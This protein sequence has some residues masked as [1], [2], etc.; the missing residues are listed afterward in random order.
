MKITHMVIALLLIAKANCTIVPS[1][2]II[3]TTISAVAL[4]LSVPHY[5]VFN[6]HLRILDFLQLVYVFS[7]VTTSMF[8]AQLSTSWLKFM[9]NFYSSFCDAGS[10]PTSVGYALSAGTVLV[11][12]IVLALLIT[13]IE[14]CRKP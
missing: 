4:A 1:Q 3:G 6:T 12:I 2:D 7:S 11:G 13:A 8:G 5:F 10:Y 9:P 14:K